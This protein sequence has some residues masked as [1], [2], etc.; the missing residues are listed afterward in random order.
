VLGQDIS[1]IIKPTVVLDPN[2]G[3]ASYILLLFTFE[4]NP[5]QFSLKSGAVSTNSKLLAAYYTHGDSRHNPIPENVLRLDVTAATIQPTRPRRKNADYL[6]AD[7][8]SIEPL[9]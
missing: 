9:V 8:R 6:M 3:T 5:S 4:R 2:T 1:Q 7:R